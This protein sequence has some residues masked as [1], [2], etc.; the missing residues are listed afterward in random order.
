MG[1]FNKSKSSSTNT[2]NAISTV[3][4]N[5]GDGNY[6][7][8]T[9]DGSGGGVSLARNINMSESSIG[10]INL[11]NKTTDH[12]AVKAGENIALA[13]IKSNAD[14]IDSLLSATSE[15]VDA[16]FDTVNNFADINS[17]T[18]EKYGELISDS[19]DSSLSSVSESTRMAINSA[20]DAAAMVSAATNNAYSNANRSILAVSQQSIDS[21]AKNISAAYDNAQNYIDQNNDDNLMA[22]MSVVAGANSMVESTNNDALLYVSEAQKTESERTTDTLLKWGFGAIA[23]VGL[24]FAFMRAK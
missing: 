21:T 1:F 22:L 24:G 17:R 14:T 4:N 10:D 16:G 5:G 18:A 3:F 6:G 11:Y 12:G 13:G 19:F 15:V 2:S 23:T 8:N 9:S 20:N 7:D